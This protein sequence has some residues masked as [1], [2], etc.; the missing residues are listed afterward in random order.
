MSRLEREVVSRAE[1]LEK[2]K[3]SPTHPAIA[4][5]ERRAAAA[6]GAVER[7]GGKAE[8]FI[9]PVLIVERHGPPLFGLRPAKYVRMQPDIVSCCDERRSL[10]RVVRRRP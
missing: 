8:T 5:A 6:E 7:I 10:A 2:R 4:V 3:R 9:E 1:L